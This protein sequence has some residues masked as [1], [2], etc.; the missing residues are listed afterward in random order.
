MAQY[1]IQRSIDLS[2]ERFVPDHHKMLLKQQMA[3]ELADA[4]LRDWGDKP[5]TRDC[6]TGKLALR[7]TATIVEDAEVDRIRRDAVTH[8]I[9][10]Q[11]QVEERNRPY[12]LD[13]VYE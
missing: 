2:E 3:R 11:R 6:M 12:G 9:R 10:T 7:F 8:G 13:E 4:F 1:E 5:F